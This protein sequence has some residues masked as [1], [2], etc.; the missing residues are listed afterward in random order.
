MSFPSAESIPSKSDYLI[1]V[2]DLLLKV[3]LCAHFQIFMIHVGLQWS[4]L[5]RLIVPCLQLPATASWF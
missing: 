4:Y 2:R 3:P 5:T 1:F